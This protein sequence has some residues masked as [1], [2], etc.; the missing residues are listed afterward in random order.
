MLERT[1]Y[2]S[3]HLS[4]E[5]ENYFRH[6]QLLKQQGVTAGAHKRF[7]RGKRNVH[8]DHFTV[9]GNGWQIPEYLKY[10]S[11]AGVPNPPVASSYNTRMR[12]AST[13]GSAAGADV[14]INAKQRVCQPINRHSRRVKQSTSAFGP[15][16]AEHARKFYHSNESQSTYEYSSQLILP[17][18][19]DLQFVRQM[20]V[21]YQ[22]YNP[23]YSDRGRCVS[24]PQFHKQTPQNKDQ[25]H[26]KSKPRK[27][28]FKIASISPRPGK[29][30]EI[31]NPSLKMGVP[32][33][34]SKEIEEMK[35]LSSKIEKELS[36]SPIY[37]ILGE[38]PRAG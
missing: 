16:H 11:Y 28:I 23:I 10:N 24:K 29:Q 14:N 18:Q 15:L 25:E 34:K 21:S 27:P 20:P 9:Y 36:C 12:S 35:L 32:N 4:F 6:R 38:L 5:R 8:N 30:N 33:C 19:Q 3:D 37:Q 17:Y 13:G 31:V 7:P 22:M 2:C 1:R 26:V